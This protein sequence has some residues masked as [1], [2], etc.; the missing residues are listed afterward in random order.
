MRSGNSR[1]TKEKGP[2]FDYMTIMTE[3]TN[4]QT[5]KKKRKKEKDIP[6]STKPNYEHMPQH[7][8]S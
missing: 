1:S 2:L 5:P 7:K 4:I 8:S 3:S 6:L